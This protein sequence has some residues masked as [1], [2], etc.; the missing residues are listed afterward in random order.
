MIKGVSGLSD[1][2]LLALVLR[3]GYAGHSALDI[4]KH[5]LETHSL[6]TLLSQP[7]SQLAAVKGVGWSRA[8]TL[9]AAVELAR[10]SLSSTIQLSI[11]SPNEIYNLT[12]FLTKKN[13][14]H[15]V[16]LY[17]NARNQLLSQETISIGTVNASLVH[18]REVFAPALR[19]HASG[20]ILVHNHPSGDPTPSPEDLV[21]TDKLEETGKIMDIPLLDHV[22]VAH[23]D[24]YSFK[25]K[26]LL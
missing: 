1:A 21:I 25:Q 8:C 12:A 22:I 13:Q 19:H 10:V 16:C 15:A 18:P 17:L 26:G 23:Q 5:L 4:A 6:P 3:S 20:L 7:L 24:W 14:E 2:E 11:R 9:H